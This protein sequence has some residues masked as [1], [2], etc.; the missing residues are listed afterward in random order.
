[1]SAWTVQLSV[2]ERGGWWRGA[3]RGQ[4]LEREGGRSPQS[5]G[6]EVTAAVSLEHPK[7]TQ[8][9]GVQ[10]PHKKITLEM[11]RE[12]VAREGVAR[13]WWHGQG[14]HSRPGTH[15]L[16]IPLPL[17]LA[18]PSITSVP[19]IPTSTLSSEI[20]LPS[21]LP[22]AEPALAKVPALMSLSPGCS[23]LQLCTAAPP[24]DIASEQPTWT[25]PHQQQCTGICMLSPTNIPY[26]HS[27]QCSPHYV[28]HPQAQ[29]HRSIG[30]QGLQ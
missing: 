17:S 11:V 15:A 25:G 16:K 5:L 7:H 30:G 10:T 9:R 23:S 2:G 26:I 6:P 3:H 22:K 4:C 1:M 8:G 28:G 24:R 13:R 19:T 21:P 18:P 29:R 20:S 12:E 14:W 27:R